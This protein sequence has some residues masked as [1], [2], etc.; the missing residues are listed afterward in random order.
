MSRG[1]GVPIWSSSER[2]RDACGSAMLGT[3][4]ESAE[5]RWNRREEEC[6][7]RGEKDGRVPCRPRA[8]SFARIVPS[9]TELLKRL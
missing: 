6:G 8:V 2:R 1:D 7:N 3:E 4:E 5:S 9:I